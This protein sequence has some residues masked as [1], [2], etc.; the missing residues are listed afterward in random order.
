M[1]HIQ[2]PRRLQGPAHRTDHTYEAMALRWAQVCNDPLLQDLPAKIELNALGVIASSPAGNR[3]GIRQAAVVRAWSARRST[4]ARQ[5]RRG[6]GSILRDAGLTQNGI[7]PVQ[8]S[9][10]MT[11]SPM[12]L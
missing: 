12:K 3:H 1:L 7:F 10:Y 2:R 6:R 5:H 8:M 9:L 11:Q 4:E